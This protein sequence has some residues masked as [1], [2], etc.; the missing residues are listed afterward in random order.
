MR[1][2]AVVRAVSRAE[3]TLAIFKP[4]LVAHPLRLADAQ[5]TIKDHGFTILRHK[6]IPFTREQAGRFYA[7][8]KGKMFYNRL[9]GF[10]SSG[11]I[12]AL[13]LARQDAIAAWRSLMGPTKVYR[14][15]YHA[16]ST[17]RGKHGLTD[18][19]NSV[20]G[21]DSIESAT[22]EIKFFFPDESYQE[23]LAE[24]SNQLNDR[25]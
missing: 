10:M 24:Y 14:T 1:G 9:V 8:H 23:L 7:E 19:R 20:H 6:R 18:T 21:S 12:E 22:A 25:E 11:P 15:H 3:C 13:V 16:P 4:D 5:Q 17:L 2:S